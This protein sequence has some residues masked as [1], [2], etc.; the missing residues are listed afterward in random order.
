M[1]KRQKRM[2]KAI[3]NFILLILACAFFLFAL[4]VAGY[5]DV[6][7]EAAKEGLTYQ[8]YLEVHGGK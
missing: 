3:R 6:S 8:E 4:A 1:T 2:A 5:M 7:T